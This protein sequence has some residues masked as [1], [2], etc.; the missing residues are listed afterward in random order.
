M[1]SAMAPDTI[2]AAVAT[3]TIWKNQSDMVACPPA[4]TPVTASAAA[5]ASPPT[6][7][8]SPADGPWRSLNEPMSPPK[9][10]PKRLRSLPTSTYMRL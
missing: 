10:T 2:D 5:S 7:A 8:T 4:T 9:S 1:R 3:K 6:R